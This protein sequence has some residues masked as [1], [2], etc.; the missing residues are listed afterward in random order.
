MTGN[1]SFWLRVVTIPRPRDAWKGTSESFTE[2]Y[3][4]KKDNVKGT[5]LK[6]GIVLHVLRS[7][8]KPILEPHVVL[9]VMTIQTE[10]DA[11]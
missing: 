2:A 9:Q 3:M 8:R 10:R 11:W 7:S 1:H 5:F 4:L 6:L